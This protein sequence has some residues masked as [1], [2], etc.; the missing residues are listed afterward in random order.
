MNCIST[1]NPSCPLTKTQ[2]CPKLY[3][4]NTL[5]GAI[6]SIPTL[7]YSNEMLY[8][9]CKN[10]SMLDKRELAGEI[11]VIGRVYAVGLERG[12]K[13][14]IPVH[15]NGTDIY[16]Q[17]IADYLVKDPD[18]I[19]L[20][21]QINA[22]QPLQFNCSQDDF[23]KLN[24]SIECVE[25]LNAL[26]KKASLSFG[27]IDYKNQISFCSKFLHF[28]A[29]ENFFIFDQYTKA[30]AKNLFQT[31]N[32]D[33]CNVAY[34]KDILVKVA[35]KK[36]ISDM[37]TDIF[38][39]VTLTILKDYTEHVKRSYALGVILKCV[40]SNY[41]VSKPSNITYPRLTDI[42]FQNIL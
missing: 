24:I 4:C 31:Q 22:L 3:T 29:P 11:L 2:I 28:Q 7:S 32:N 16:F 13:G 33:V 21:N 15:G 35:D 5:S 37:L 6:Q 19:N 10:G 9:M 1:K 18:F 17:H 38:N 39:G 8:G 20:V 40:E 26:I 23:D 14:G 27:G 25:K 41:K 30:N 42:I 34:G 36:L 12:F